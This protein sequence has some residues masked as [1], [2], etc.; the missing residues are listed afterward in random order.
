[1]QSSPHADADP[2]FLFDIA[3]Y[4]IIFLFVLPRHEGRF[5]IVTIRGAGCGGRGGVRRPWR[6][7]D[8]PACRVMSR[9]ARR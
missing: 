5:A 1:M 8:D 9:A 7:G 3:F 2:E 4:M 6:V